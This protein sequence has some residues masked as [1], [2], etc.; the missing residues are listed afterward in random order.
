MTVTLPKTPVATIES[1]AQADTACIGIPVTFL[2]TINTGGGTGPAYAWFK[3]TTQIGGQNQG[4]LTVSNLANGDSVRLRLT[5]TGTCLTSNVVFSPAIRIAIVTLTSNAG[6]DTTVC[7]GSSVQL[8]GRPAGGTWSGNNVVGSG[9]F[10]APGSGSSLLTYTVNKYGCSK[11]DLKVVSVFQIP[12]VTFGV[13]TD[14]LTGNA[15]GATAWAW[16]LNGNIIQGANSRKLTIQESGEYCC[17]ATFGNGCSKKSLCQQVTFSSISMLEN[18]KGFHVWPN[19]VNE[20]LNIRWNGKASKIN[21]YNAEGKVL[22]SMDAELLQGKANMN[23]ENLPT[24]L[25]RLVIHKENG[26]SLGMSLMHQ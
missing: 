6:I 2:S 5:V 8:K 21:L 25:Y 4:T 13:N 1:D 20:M 26:S 10:T 23:M 11:T 16:Y 17:E 18:E 19:P 15:T 14:T 7:P 22:V 12:N 3:N 9:I 24:G